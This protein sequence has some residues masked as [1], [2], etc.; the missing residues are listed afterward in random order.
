[1][2]RMFLLSTIFVAMLALSGQQALTQTPGVKAEPKQVTISIYHIAPGK[3]VEFLG[4]MEARQSISES[5]GFE[6]ANWYAHIDG[7]SW[8]YIVVAPMLTEE[9]EKQVEA[10]SQRRGLTTGFAAGIELRHYMLSHTDTIAIGPVSA[11]EL[12][13]MAQGRAR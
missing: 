12:A 11:S 2:K 7:D 8:D 9:Q 3:H 13:S 4:W 6:L 1:M 10:Q 5:L